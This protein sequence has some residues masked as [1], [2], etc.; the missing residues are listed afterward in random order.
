MDDDRFPPLLRVLLTG[1]CAVIVLV[2][3][4]AAADLL[5]P[6]LVTLL[7]VLAATPLVLNL[8]Q[9][10]IPPRL[11]RTG[12]YI[13]LV[14]VGLL[15]FVYV[16]RLLGEF[17]ANLPR[18]QEELDART[19]QLETDLA[20]A[21]ISV[22][23]QDLRGSFLHTFVVT[24]VNQ[25]S[26]TMTTLVFVFPAALL[27]LMESPRLATQLPQRFSSDE[28]IMAEFL[29][30]QRSVTEFL[31]IT[32]QAGFLLAAFFA[33]WLWLLGVN[34]P[35]LWGILAFLVSFIP[36][37][38]LVF[39]AIPPLIMAWI[40]FGFLRAVLVVI[41]LIGISAAVHHRMGRNAIARR[42][43]LSIAVL[44]L[45]AFFWTW[46]L[47]PFGALLAAPIMALVKLLLESSG[48]TRWLAMLM[49]A[50][51]DE[52]GT[53]AEFVQRQRRAVQVRLLDRAHK[54]AVT[55]LGWIDRQRR[56][57][58]RRLQGHRHA[59]GRSNDAPLGDGH[60]PPEQQ[61]EHEHR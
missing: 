21:G 23:L 44:Y 50:Q 18:Y 37:V 22:S 42:L 46:I 30:Y 39:A 2:G 10:G 52:L 24:M 55:G 34:L 9:R 33:A 26:R 47:G 43:D 61:T 25:I 20:S 31:V 28:Q 54:A 41:G 51:K 8:Q 16:T 13:A 11:A 27:V 49:S 4:R 53:G 3:M 45:G 7:A 15:L 59:A 38:G 32:A 5:V 56:S 1:A 36:G 17:T 35:I 12:V 48:Q 14:V 40:Q 19:T 60:A 29:R 6:F 57:L 58:T